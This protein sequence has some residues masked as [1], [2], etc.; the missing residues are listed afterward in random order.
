M[1]VFS[2]TT[3]AKPSVKPAFPTPSASVI[4]L[5]YSSHIARQISECS[6]NFQEKLTSKASVVVQP[7]R[8]LAATKQLTSSLSIIDSIR[9]LYRICTV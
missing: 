2:P 6:E 4:H 1:G 9:G 3:N 8:K 7:T 5:L